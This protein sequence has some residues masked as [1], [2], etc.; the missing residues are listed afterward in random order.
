MKSQMI[1]P[2]PGLKKYEFIPLCLYASHKNDHR[3][4]S[5]KLGKC[6]FFVSLHIKRIIS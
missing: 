3:L 6:T 1:A 2:N 5:V 4:K